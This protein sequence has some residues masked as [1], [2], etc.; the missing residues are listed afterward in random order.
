[1]W[2]AWL[3]DR[4]CAGV[5]SG[6]VMLAERCAPHLCSYTQAVQQLRTQLENLQSSLFLE[7][8]WLAACA[9]SPDYKI[10]VQAWDPKWSNK[11]IHVIA[12]S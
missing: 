7:T 4:L 12:Q 5:K 10:W 9:R 1:M 11:P 2:P 3:G 6:C 8:P